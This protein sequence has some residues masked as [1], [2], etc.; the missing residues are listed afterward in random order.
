MNKIFNN[1]FFVFPILLACLACKE[2]TPRRPVT[3]SSGTFLQISSKRNKALYEAEKKQIEALIKKQP[4]KTYH[5]ST[6]GFWYAYNTKVNNDSTTVKFGDMVNFD[7]EVLSLDGTTIYPTQN[8]TYVIDK[9]I[10]FKGLREGL[11]L[12]KS[13]ESITFIFPSSLAYG[14]YGDE[15]KIKNNIPLICNVTLNSII[16]NNE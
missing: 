13:N 9:E 3:K 5:T 12:M 2:I 14:Y 15:D 1:T 6:N 8:K 10:L 11:K 16:K 4:Q 7:F